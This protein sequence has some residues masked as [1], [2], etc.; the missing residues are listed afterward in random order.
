MRL[1][2][3]IICMS[4]LSLFSYIPATAHHR[5]VPFTSYL[6]HYFPEPARVFD[7]TCIRKADQVQLT[8]K[9]EN[10]LA[11]DRLIVQRSSNGRK[12]EMA[13]LV[14]SSE[15]GPA[16][17]YRFLDRNKNRKAYYR[18]I[19]INKDKSVSYSPVIRMASE[20]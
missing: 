9:L 7:L 2:P 1:I 17:L 11:A 5:S 20:K 12:F 14:F 4:A 15:E 13:G 8:W 3:T 16:E 10:N 18:I 19:I 6:N